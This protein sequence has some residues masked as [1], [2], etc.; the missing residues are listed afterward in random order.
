M[1]LQTIYI[2]FIFTL[3]TSVIVAQEAELKATVSKNKLA[4]NQRLRLQFSI[5]KQGADNFKP[6]SFK[7][8][9]IVGGPSQSINQ[10][11]I[12][13]K[14]SFTKSYTY[15][16][17]PLRKGELSIPSATI[18]FRGE[19]L[20]S[21]PIKIIVLDPVDLPKDPND[22]NYIAEQ[23][24]HLVA[25]VSKTRPYIGEGIYV[26]YKLYVSP[27]ISVLDYSLTESPQYNGFWNQ[28]IKIN[29]L[30]VRKGKYNGEEYRYVVLK[31][32]LLIPTKTGKLSIDPIKMNIVIGVPSGRIDFFGNSI[33]KNIRRE[34]ASPKKLILPKELPLEGKP[35]NFNGA[36]G[37]FNFAVS[38]SKDLLKANETSQIKVVVTGKGNLKLFEIPTIK[39]P[40]ELEVYTPEHQENVSVTPSGIK[41]S[42]SDQYTVVPQYK[43]KYKI[44][45]VSFSYFDPK[46]KKYH[47]L[48][49]E[50][51]F[52][53]VLEGKTIANNSDAQLAL[54]QEVVVT[55]DNF[56]Y[57]QT[58]SEFKDPKTVEFFNTFWFYVLLLFPLLW[59]PI[60]IL[61]SHKMEKYN[62]DIIGN[63]K[64]KANRL[65]KKYLSE[66]AKKLGNKE[67]FYEALEKALH[68]YLKAK[69][70]VETT[71]IS[72]DNI[73]SML[74]E[75]NIQNTTIQEFLNVLKECD[76]ARY[77][78]TTNSEMQ[79][80]YE[81]A[82]EVI[83]ALDK[84]F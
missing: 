73:T 80:E 38:A 79:Q 83:A 66:A 49:S 19:K 71:D 45:N 32:A 9:K 46:E 30:Q 56:Q 50:D 55:G 70:Q 57:I 82:K 4:L 7:N 11:W 8:F 58:K 77:T 3:L 14:A 31:R 16:I 69:L 81:K 25:E 6:P 26:E 34:F 47:T 22:P 12:N 13:G 75:K 37:D 41:G 74:T 43:G 42:I 59:I 65:A 29:G 33:S 27:N 76:F 23:N 68:N 15:S 60:G 78:P 51:L 84:Q 39:T 17:Q 48:L 28:D 72:S 20:Q 67:H 62:S 54:K 40:T 10:S 64:R 63:K 35:D 36:V 18:E 24:I 53:N 1:K 5:N 44:P 52:V 21:K 61:V 2:L